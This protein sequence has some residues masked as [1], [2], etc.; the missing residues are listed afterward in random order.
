M[1][2]I[3]AGAD[4]RVHSH[5]SAAN[6]RGK[7][8]NRTM[9]LLYL[10]ATSVVM[11]TSALNVHWCPR[12]CDC[13]HQY[14][15]VDCSARGL[16]TVPPLSNLTERL[17]LED[18]MLDELPDDALDNVPRLNVL[19]LHNNH[20][21]HLTTAA[22]CA[23]PVLDELTLN[24]N[25]LR[26]IEV[27]PDCT[28][29]HLHQLEVHD[30][31]LLRL[32]ANLSV[33]APALLTLNASY[34]QLG[35][36]QL[37]DSYAQ[38]QQLHT[39]DLRANNIHFLHSADLQPVAS[40]LH[41]LHLV[42]CGLLDVDADA[43]ANMSNLTVLSL[44]RNL[45]DADTLKAALAHSVG[46]QRL[47][48]S[49][50]YLP[51]VREAML[52]HLPHLTHLDVSDSS[53]EHIDPELWPRMPAL[54]VLQL[55]HNELTDLGNVS[56]L[57]QLRKL[58]VSD[59][60]LT[61]LDVRELTN[62]DLL[63]ASYNALQELPAGWMVGTDVLFMLNLS[64]NAL[65]VID[66]HA[67]QAVTLHTLDLSHNRLK[68]LQTLGQIK[69][70]K[71]H[72][73]NNRLTSIAPDAFRHLDLTLE[74]LDLSHNNLTALPAARHDFVSLQSLNLAHNN[75]GDRKSVV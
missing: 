63:D 58:H 75:L 33:F 17:Y 54:E 69:L 22:L 10:I 31:K 60:Q 71:L 11:P 42:D 4:G 27:D 21:H 45:L 13:Y 25:G 53:I 73:H 3:T 8:T 59:N 64:H 20:L 66:H 2:G 49:D 37:D 62:L 18:N 67:F 70:S 30:N 65:E 1:V 19:T 14:S 7:L 32:P 29:P 43:F 52:G 12:Q 38:F 39:L 34:N 57:S 55:D 68:R 50:M 16:A 23:L 40:T 61:K 26:E 47:D 5:T 51:E 24:G 46:L 36:A 44:Q 72:L 28:A 15:V 9:W 56:M 48:L 74:D 35:S 41:V 6:R